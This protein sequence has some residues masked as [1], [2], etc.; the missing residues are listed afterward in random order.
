M[1]LKVTNNFVLLI[2]IIRRAWKESPAARRHT[3]TLSES[4]PA[5]LSSRGLRSC[6]RATAY[7]G[8]PETS[9]PLLAPRSVCL[10]VS[11]F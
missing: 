8:E 9:S 11:A 2:C 10:S 6:R 7:T 1:W 3:P 4:H 5:A